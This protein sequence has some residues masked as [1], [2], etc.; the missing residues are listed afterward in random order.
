[1]ASA[2]ESLSGLHK[3]GVLCSLK[4][5]MTLRVNANRAQLHPL[6]LLLRLM[7]STRAFSAAYMKYALL[8]EGDIS[9]VQQYAFEAR[10][11]VDPNGDGAAVYAWAYDIKNGRHAGQYLHT[12][13][14]RGYSSSNSSIGGTKNCPARRSL[15]PQEKERCLYWVAIAQLPVDPLEEYSLEV[16]ERLH[17]QQPGG[18]VRT[19]LNRNGEV[20]RL[21]CEDPAVQGGG[22]PTPPYGYY[23]CRNPPCTQIEQHL[24]QFS[25]CGRCQEARYCG[26]FCQQRDWPVHKKT[27][28]PKARPAAS[29]AT[30]KSPER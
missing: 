26:T 12:M 4:I 24:R 5:D 27:C 15:T 22:L 20:E 29:A 16:R 1:M 10:L 21:V 3:P 25:I 17:Q 7:I 9:L 30:D 8:D 13:L 11:E 2:C 23:E 28:Q 6:R 18:V 14:W 19:C